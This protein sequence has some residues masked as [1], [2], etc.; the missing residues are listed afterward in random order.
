MWYEAKI[1]VGGQFSVLKAYF[2]KE[3]MGKKIEKN[4]QSKFKPQC[5]KNTKFNAKLKKIM[6]NRNKSSSKKKNTIEKFNRP[7]TEYL[8]ILTDKAPA[9]FIKKKKINYQYYK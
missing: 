1:R 4:Q 2:R 7:K 9:R 8:K 5:S 6:K 3:S